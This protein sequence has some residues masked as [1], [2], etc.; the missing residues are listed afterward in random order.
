M[1]AV[2]TKKQKNCIMILGAIAAVFGAV[3]G[4]SGLVLREKYLMFD[5][6]DWDVDVISGF[7]EGYFGVMSGFIVSLSNGSLPVFALIKIPY[8]LFVFFLFY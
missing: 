1:S 3:A 4:A 2:I 6:Q 7:T 5:D 8:L